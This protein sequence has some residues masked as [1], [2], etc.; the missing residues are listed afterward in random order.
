MKLRQL[1][2][3]SCRWRAT[4]PAASKRAWCVVMFSLPYLLCWPIKSVAAE[5]QRIDFSATS[6]PLRFLQEIKELAQHG[7]LRD[8]DFV[9]RVLGVHFTPNPDS[10]IIEGQKV[11]ITALIPDRPTPW[12]RRTTFNFTIIP[13]W[14]PNYFKPL[15]LINFAN[16]QFSV[17]IR[18][19]DIYQSIGRTAEFLPGLPFNWEYGF[20]TVRTADFQTSVQVAYPPYTSRDCIQ[21]LNVAENPA[22]D[23]PFVE[24][25]KQ[26]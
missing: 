2:L 18:S 13:E 1:D 4:R 21:S 3:C 12:D 8:V 15:A 20:T 25:R 5:I 17:C 14:S 6:A 22:H 7:E 10:T 16:L 24:H 19:W 9:S 11:K 26:R 23:F